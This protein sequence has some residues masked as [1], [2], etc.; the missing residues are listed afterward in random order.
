MTRIQWLGL[1]AVLAAW[2][3]AA[4]DGAGRF[5]IRGAGLLTC[6][7]YVKE[8]AKKS[9]AYAMI[10]GWLDGYITGLNQFSS[11]TYDVTSFES[12]ELLAYILETHCRDNPVDRLFPVVNTIFAK[13]NEDRLRTG[14]P[15]VAV[16]VGEREVPLYREVVRRMQEE[17]KRRGHYRG[18]PTG[19]FETAT[20]KAVAAFQRAQKLTPTGFPDQTTLWRLLRRTPSAK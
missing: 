4:A 15:I 2:P 11:E 5:S 19:E 13:L 12:T 3:V 8:R 20:E 9:S 16:R 1:L 7:I 6:D 17:L 14:S 10:G 18:E